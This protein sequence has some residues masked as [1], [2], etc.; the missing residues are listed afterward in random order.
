[1]RIEIL[2]VENI[3][4]RLVLDEE[5]PACNKA[6]YVEVNT[7]EATHPGYPFILFC[8]S[9]KMKRL[10]KGSVVVVNSNAT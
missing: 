10:I 2:T 4:G 8:S 3:Q 1:M 7:N 6:L 5:C 9:C